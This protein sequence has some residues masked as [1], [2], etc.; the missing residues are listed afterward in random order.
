[1]SKVVADFSPGFRRESRPRLL[2][3]TLGR[4]DE[5]IVMQGLGRSHTTWYFLNDNLSI[6]VN[7]IDYLVL[8][9]ATALNEKVSQAA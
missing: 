2:A 7:N 9:S 5:E 8:G 3:P 4:P 6:H 1:V